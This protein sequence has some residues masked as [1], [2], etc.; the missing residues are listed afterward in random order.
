MHRLIF[1]ITLLAFVNSSANSADTKG[2]TMP[3]SIV[4]IEKKYSA[5]KSMSASFDQTKTIKAFKLKKSSQGVV[6]IDRP[7]KIRWEH[8]A[9]DKTIMVGDGNI[10]KVYTPPFDKDDRGQ[11]IIE[12]A[13]RIHSSI[14]RDLL[15]GAFSLIKG[16][17]VKQIEPNVYELT[18]RNPKK[19]FDGV[20]KAHIVIDTIKSEIRNVALF[21]VGG[22]L[23]EITFKDVKLGEKLK[24]GLFDISP[25]KDNTD[26][27]D[28]V[29]ES[30]KK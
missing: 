17:E 20:A 12:K 24:A 30:S 3:A 19:S 26:I 16:V 7:D 6:F 11:L 9:P 5:S 15:S 13:S 14:I 23:T 27:T 10:I 28:R 1:I 18:P 29:T 2:S 25:P 21:H 8:S 4:E 22:N